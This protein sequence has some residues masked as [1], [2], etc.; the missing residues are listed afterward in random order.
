MRPTRE[1][2]VGMLLIALLTL[3]FIVARYGRVLPWAAR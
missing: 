2:A 1:L 3:V